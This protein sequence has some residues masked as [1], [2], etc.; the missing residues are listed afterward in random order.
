[1][2]KASIILFLFYITFFLLMTSCANS[3]KG[4]FQYEYRNYSY[5]VEITYLNG[6]VDTVYHN[7]RVKWYKN[8]I[9]EES[10]MVPTLEMVWAEPC[11]YL[12]GKIL[13]VNIRYFRILEQT[14]ETDSI[15]LKV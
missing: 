12:R 10:S 3:G 1:M 6:D 5:K 7:E 15:N 4:E 8:V 14:W 11:L 13:C 9:S 2:K